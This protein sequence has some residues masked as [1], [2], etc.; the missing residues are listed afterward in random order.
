MTK[1]DGLATAKATLANL[2]SELTRVDG[3]LTEIGIGRERVAH[4]ALTGDATA[5]EKLEALKREAAELADHRKDVVAAIG[6]AEHL[7]RLGLANEKRREEI[8]AAKRRKEFATN[9][10]TVGSE[11]DQGKLLGLASIARDAGQLGVEF[12][13][14]QF[15]GPNLMNALH[16]M[17]AP[18]HPFMDPMSVRKLSPDQRITFTKLLGGWADRIDA[19]ADRVIAGKSESRKEAA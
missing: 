17:I 11:A 2:N 7:V 6:H 19:E 8:A 4:G 3:R 16:T 9:L 14:V 1:P 12:L 10:R 5:R 15:V 13:H 18:L